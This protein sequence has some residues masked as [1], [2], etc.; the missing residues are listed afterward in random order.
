MNI[1]IYGNFTLSR[2]C[3]FSQ[4]LPFSIITVR[5]IQLYKLAENDIKI[6]REKSWGNR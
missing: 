2:R 5:N 3:H 1:K 6:A 4:M